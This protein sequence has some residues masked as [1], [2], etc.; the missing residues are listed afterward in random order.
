M[1]VP[2]ISTGTQENQTSLESQF[3]LSFLSNLIHFFFFKAL[4]VIYFLINVI[5]NQ[6]LLVI[7]WFLT[8]GFLFFS[9]NFIE[10]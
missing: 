6:F 10:E 1:D 2:T 4:N 3:P 5:K 8:L 7:F 9:P